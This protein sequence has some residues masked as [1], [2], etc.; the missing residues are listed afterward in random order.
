VKGIT[1]ASDRLTPKTAAEILGL[2]PITIY[3]YVRQGK[4]KA[5]RKSDNKLYFTRYDIEEFKTHAEELVAVVPGN[6]PK[7]APITGKDLG[8]K[9]I[10]GYLM[11]IAEVAAFLRVSVRWVEMHIND[12]TFPVK[13]YPVGTRGR[14]FDSADV[15]DWLLKIFTEAG[16]APLPLKAERKI[17]R[18]KEAA[19]K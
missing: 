16:T 12:G 18:E 3:G 11:T 4:L 5:Y 6:V 1:V 10:R 15:E 8:M 7:N 9:K 19:M 2:S 17:R 13:S 14:V